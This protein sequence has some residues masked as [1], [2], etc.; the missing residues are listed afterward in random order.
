MRAYTHAGGRCEEALSPEGVCAILGKRDAQALKKT[1][2]CNFTTNVHLH[3]VR[4]S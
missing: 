4:L 2:Q 1:F 3:R